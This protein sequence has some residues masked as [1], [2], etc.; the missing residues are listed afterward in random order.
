M[1]ND[2][3]VQVP[4]RTLFGVACRFFHTLIFASIGL[5]QSARFRMN[6][7]GVSPLNGGLGEKVRT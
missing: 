1:E 7:Y 2:R 6:D 5:I 4:Y 3:L